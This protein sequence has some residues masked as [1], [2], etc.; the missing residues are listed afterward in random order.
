M[1]KAIYT[2]KWTQT[3]VEEFK[4]E[5]N[6]EEEAIEWVENNCDPNMID[7]NDLE[8]ISMEE[9]IIIK[10]TNIQ[11]DV[12][13]LNEQDREDV[14][15]ELPTEIDIPE[16]ITDLDDIEDYILE[17]SDGWAFTEYTPIYK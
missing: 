4:V 15:S 13:E 2:V 14:L 11:W 5:A 9:K 8:V 10:A 3:L 17:Q 7:N 1:A 16:G 6:S 12:E